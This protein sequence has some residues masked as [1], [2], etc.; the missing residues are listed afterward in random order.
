MLTMIFPLFWNV[1]VDPFEV[2][3]EH[4]MFVKTQSKPF[5]KCGKPNY[6]R[7]DEPPMSN[8][9]FQKLLATPNGTNEYKYSTVNKNYT[10]VDPKQTRRHV[11]G[12]K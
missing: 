12:D 2:V 4:K 11:K 8:N 3:H 7:G 6:V 1:F 5:A 10:M 9:S